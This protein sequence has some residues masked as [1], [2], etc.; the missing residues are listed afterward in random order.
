[1]TMTKYL[2]IAI[3]ITGFLVGNLS[4]C[5][6]ITT[7]YKT[8]KAECAS[9]AYQQYPI[10]NHSEVKTE[11]REVRVKTGEIC[12]QKNSGRTHCD[13][14]YAYKDEPYQK[15]VSVDLNAAIRDQTISSC[16]RSQCLTK[17]GNEKC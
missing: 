10:D 13:T 4:G 11:Y 5:A 16:T 9:Q 6:T 7:E 8:V 3:L 12:R 15:K 14:S 1:M 17:Y 2:A